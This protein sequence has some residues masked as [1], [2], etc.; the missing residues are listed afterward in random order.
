MPE[1]YR[2][3]SPNP[4][5]LLFHRIGFKGFDG[6]VAQIPRKSVFRVDRNIQYLPSDIRDREP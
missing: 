3:C 2:L 4:V 5:R 1:V 6:R